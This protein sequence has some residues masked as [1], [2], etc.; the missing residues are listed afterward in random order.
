MIKGSCTN[1]C[2]IGLVPLNAAKHMCKPMEEQVCP[3]C[4]CH[5][6][7]FWHFLECPHPTQVTAFNKLWS[8]LQSLH[9]K[10]SVDLHLFQ[11][12]W[13]GLLSIRYSISIDEQLQAYPLGYQDLFIKQQHIGWDQLFY[14][15]IAVS[16]ADKI[17]LDSNGTING[18]VF[19]LQV[20]RIIWQYILD[21]WKLCNTDLHSPQLQHLT[22]NTLAHQV[23]Q[24]F[25]QMHMDPLLQ[26][27]APSITVDQVLHR[28]PSAIREW[29][30]SS[31]HLAY[32]AVFVSSSPTCTSAHP[33]YLQFPSQ[34]QSLVSIFAFHARVSIMWVFCIATC[35]P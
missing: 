3:S 4:H 22:Q 5:K 14:G 18:T 16:W 20:I 30:R 15:H 28:P 29:I 31:M 27:I 21:I 12:L 34:P 17:T 32:S 10:N 13:E 7:D 8:S 19:Y 35:S 25:H 6:E 33:R 24:I 1:S 23:Q 9:Q 2:I 11:L 26:P